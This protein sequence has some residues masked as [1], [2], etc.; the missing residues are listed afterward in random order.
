MS[1]SAKV[2]VPN[3][4]ERSSSGRSASKDEYILADS[5]Q[6]TKANRQDRRA[7]QNMVKGGC[8]L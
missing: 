7:G 4:V 5:T 1:L 2:S 3:A 6:I 8:G